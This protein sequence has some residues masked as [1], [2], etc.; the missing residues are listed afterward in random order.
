MNH[1]YHEDHFMCAGPCQKPMAMSTPFFQKE[2]KPYCKTD[3]DILFAR[4]EKSFKG[5]N[6]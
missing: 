3:Y 6:T 5:K 1:S 2:G 4:C